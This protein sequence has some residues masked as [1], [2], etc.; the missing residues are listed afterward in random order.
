MK[1]KRFK[2][3][4][5]D[6]RVTLVEAESK[7]D[8][9]SV[10]KVLLRETI[11]KD[12]V[13]EICDDVKKGKQNGGYTYRNIKYRLFVIFLFPMTS[14]KIRINILGHEKR[15]VEDR[16]AE[17]IQLNDIEGMA[18]LAGFLAEKLFVK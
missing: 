3:P 11:H 5:Y 15:H 2:I 1:V 12:D 14:Q 16:L 4:I 13:K 9:D 6:F 17:H 18:F 8:S 10:S 7:E